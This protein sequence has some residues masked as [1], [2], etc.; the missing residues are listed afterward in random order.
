MIN[1]V[2]YICNTF[3]LHFDY[4]PYPKSSLISMTN[5]ISS[6]KQLHPKIQYTQ[7]LCFNIYIMYSM[8]RPGL[9]VAPSIDQ[10]VFFYKF[11]I[12]MNKIK[13]FETI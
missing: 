2:A 12:I 1:Y 3:F 4:A 13:V 10:V 11:S 9:V 7:K 6:W 5:D 8:Q